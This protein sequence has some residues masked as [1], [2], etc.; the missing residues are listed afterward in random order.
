MALP[1]NSATLPLVIAGRMLAT[2]M[3]LRGAERLFRFL[4]P[5]EARPSRRFEVYLGDLRYRGDTANFVDWNILLYG[6][7]EEADLLMM[8]AY[9]LA[10]DAEVFLDVGA[11]LG[12]HALYLYGATQRVVAIEPN[13]RLHAQFRE[14]LALNGISNIGIHDVALGSADRDGKLYLGADSGGS[15]LLKTANDLGGGDSVD[16]MVRAGDSFIRDH[17]VEGRIGLIKIDVEGLE[18]Q[19]LKGFAGTINEHRPLVLLEISAAGKEQFESAENFAASFP[20][21][22]AF[23]TWRDRGGIRR[24]SELGQASPEA[25]FSGHGNVY[26]VPQE[27]RERFEKSAASRPSRMR[28]RQ[29]SYVRL[30]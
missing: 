8:K 19:V 4:F 9:A 11:N 5:P 7:Y 28:H 20:N 1:I 22:Y 30:L 12:Q 10:G 2:A 6:A 16:V 25:I 14:N 17:A 27:K 23:Y 24:E 26:A 18:A 15:S 13:T 21:A 29:M 3:R